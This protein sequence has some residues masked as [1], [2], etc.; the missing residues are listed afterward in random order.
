MLQAADLTLDDFLGLEGCNE[1]LN[2]TRPDVLRRHPPRVLRGRR[3]RRRDQHLR[4]QPAQPRRLRHLATGS[5]NCPRRAPGWPVRSPTR[6]D[7]AATAW[8]AS[9]SARW[10]REPSSP[11]L[12]HAP[13]AVLRD[14]YTEAALGMI[15][16][17]ADAI[18]VETCQDLLQVKAAII[19]SQRAMETA[20]VAGCRSSPTSRW[21]PPAPCCS[22]ARSARR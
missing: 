21:R 7:P 20:R 14:A 4:L 16:G 18:L 19:G 3:R 17:G 22:A 8:P 11:R 12:G 9:C 10:G 5:A 2:D 13:F 15:D 6:W 1:I